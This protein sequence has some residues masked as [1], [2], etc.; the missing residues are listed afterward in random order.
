VPASPRERRDQQPEIALPVAHLRLLEG[1]RTSPHISAQ[2]A[3]PPALPTDTAAVTA[4]CRGVAALLLSAQNHADLTAAATALHATSASMSGMWREGWADAAAARAD[5]FTTLSRFTSVPASVPDAACL[6]HVLPACALLAAGLPACAV[7][8]LASVQACVSGEA[9]VALTPSQCG[10]MLR[11]WSHTLATAS[12]W[13]DAAAVLGAVRLDAVSL[14]LN[15]ALQAG[16]PCAA[17]AVVAVCSSLTAALV[18]HLRAAAASLHRHALTDGTPSWCATVVVALDACRK[19]ANT[20]PVALSR[21][22]VAAVAHAAR[23]W[24]VVLHTALWGSTVVTDTLR[25]CVEAVVARSMAG[26]PHIAEGWSHVSSLASIVARLQPSALD[27]AILSPRCCAVLASVLTSPADAMAWLPDVEAL[28]AWVSDQ[29]QAWHRR[30]TAVLQPAAT[31]EAAIALLAAVS[32]YLPLSCTTPAYTAA[33]DLLGKPGF[34][35]QAATALVGCV[36]R[37]TVTAALHLKPSPTLPPDVEAAVT[38]LAYRLPDLDEPTAGCVLALV[39]PRPAAEVAVAAAFGGALRQGASCRLWALPAWWKTV[40]RLVGTAP[41]AASEA[42][43]AVR[44]S[45]MA[46]VCNT[47]ISS[48]DCTASLTVDVL[49]VWLWCVTTS[50]RPTTPASAL[51]DTASTAALRD[52]LRSAAAALEHVTVPVSTTQLASSAPDAH[53][54]V[55]TDSLPYLHHEGTPAPLALVPTGVSSIDIVPSTVTGGG[56]GDMESR[57]GGS[58]A[59]AVNRSVAVEAAHIGLPHARV[60]SSAAQVAAVQTV[61]DQLA[62]WRAPPPG[63]SLPVPSAFGLEWDYWRVHGASGGRADAAVAARHVADASEVAASQRRKVAASAIVATLKHPAL[64]SLGAVLAFAD[65]WVQRGGLAAAPVSLSVLQP[66]SWVAALQSWAAVSTS[67]F[68]V[69]HGCTTPVDVGAWASTLASVC[70]RLLAMTPSLVPSVQLAAVTAVAHLM[71]R[72]CAAGGPRREEEWWHAW[73]CAPAHPPSAS[74]ASVSAVAAAAFPRAAPAH[75]L[76]H[77]ALHHAASLAHEDHLGDLAAAWMDVLTPPCAVDA[78][79]SSCFVAAAPLLPMLV[80]CTA[81]LQGSRAL[82]PHV[83]AA[84]AAVLRLGLACVP[85]LCTGS[86]RRETHHL[87]LS[88]CVA[89]VDG[90]A[91]TPALRV[92]GATMLLQLARGAPGHAMWSSHLTVL[93]TL[94]GACAQR[95]VDR[96]DINAA[97]AECYDAVLAGSP[98]LRSSLV[99][100]GRARSGM[101]GSGGSGAPAASGLFVTPAKPLKPGSVGQRTA[102]GAST[103]G[104]GSVGSVRSC[105]G[106]GHSHGSPFTWGA[107][108]GAGTGA[109]VSKR[110]VL[111]AT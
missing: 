69:L 91:S 90:I 79:C 45:E 16:G 47:A 77:G 24:N 34:A 5:A 48:T 40:A 43:A 10:S 41:G 20:A 25:R 109:R 66:G 78:G 52:L 85:T 105:H 108:A 96:S 50:S 68:R 19:R 53:D 80:A 67:C 26:T 72:A 14:L 73:A 17:D 27:A 62:A 93:T 2:A 18:T 64:A 15:T 46:A 81:R 23:A 71:E 97:L 101:G 54:T 98:R 11:A 37:A 28:A 99:A 61:L 65:Q 33:A 60:A 57:W 31:L 12:C 56:A 32:P 3:A 1:G 76:W 74:S 7:S 8:V 38:E 36:F 94:A 42:Q 55:P 92:A 103:G 51:F 89:A 111:T 30:H 59:T 13:E 9:R 84:V 110:L 35:G 75:R 83:Q 95:E 39:A 106:H 104:P 21:G 86:L 6:A 100:G 88:L 63:R 107:S 22:G 44:L 29:L 49:M 58:A 4:A 82:N 87:W 102:G 70:N